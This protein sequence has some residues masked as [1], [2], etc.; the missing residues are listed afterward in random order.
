MDKKTISSHFP[1][2]LELRDY[3]SNEAADVYLYDN[4][5]V[6]E[7]KE[8]TTLSFK[9]GFSLLLKGLAILGTKPWIYISNRI[10]SYAVVPT[11]Y[12]YLNKVPTLKGLAIVNSEK[13]SMTNAHLEENFFKKPFIIVNSLEEAYQW[14]RNILEDH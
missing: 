11:D 1:E 5:A 7:V 14:G 3:F 10:H 6:V 12:K 4:F 8:G 9:N 2:N 13:A